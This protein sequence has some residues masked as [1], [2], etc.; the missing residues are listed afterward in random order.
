MSR[1]K[2]V[3]CAVGLSI[4]A[5]GCQTKDGANAE[6]SASAT[7]AASAKISAQPTGSATP[8]TSASTGGAVSAESILNDEGGE[9]SG[10]LDVHIPNDTKDA[11]M[12]GGGGAP[13]VPSGRPALTWIPAGPLAV[14]NPGWQLDD[15]ENAL[16]APDKKAAI[17]FQ[18]YTTPADSEKKVDALVKF[19][20]LTNP[21]WKKPKVVHIGPD[22]LTGVFGAGRATSAKGKTAKLFY[23]AVQTG[24]PVNLLAV[25]LANED[26]PADELE[27]ALQIVGSIK[28]QR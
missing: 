20:R 14:P 7:S 21:I 18:P 3:C 8:A 16:I 25:G 19:L 24:G 23:A 28:R 13:M 22:K 6:A 12:L 11:P 4:A 10:V 9:G 15:R 26:T 5:L 2:L 27:T 17:V 1:M